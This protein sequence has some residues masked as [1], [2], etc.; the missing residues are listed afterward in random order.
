MR[1]QHDRDSPLLVKRFCEGLNK[2]THNDIMNLDIW[3]ETLDEWQEATRRV[4][5]WHAIRQ[6]RIGGCGNWNLSTHAARWKEALDG[7]NKGRQNKVKDKD[8]MQVDTIR[9]K[10]NQ[11]KNEEIN[12]VQLTRLTPEE[13]IKLAKEGRCFRCRNTRH[14]SRNC[15]RNKNPQVGNQTQKPWPPWNNQSQNQGWHPNNNN[16]QNPPAYTCTTIS[17]PPSVPEKQK[18]T[19]EDLVTQIKNLSIDESD[20]LLESMI[21]EQEEQDEGGQGSTSLGF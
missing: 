5:R 19:L 18:Q 10:T 7:N 17:K 3:P 20:K 14:I 6:E 4:I 11:T 16:V 13:C 9:V 21:G 8:R 12:F 1:L 2:G 15:D